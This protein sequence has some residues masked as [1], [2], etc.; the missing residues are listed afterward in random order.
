MSILHKAS[1][2]TD[3]THGSISKLLFAFAVPLML[4]NLFRQLYNTVDSLIVGNFVS[5]QALA[6]VGCT[7]PIINTLIGLFS[8]LAA[9][10]SVVISQYY[11]AKDEE[12]LGKAVHTTVMITL[13]TC[14]VLTVVGVWATP[15][16]LRLMD[17]PADV[18]ASTSAG[19]P[20]CCCTI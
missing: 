11:G 6:A 15:L 20:A 5:K 9:G 1:H 4:G 18:I 17:T 12:K 19:Y 10:A 13:I 2:D 14:V 3:M 16:M 7:G 8:G